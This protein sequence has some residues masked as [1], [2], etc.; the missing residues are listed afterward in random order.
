M[1][2]HLHRPWLPW[3][4][5]LVLLIA[6]TAAYWP[7]F[8]GVFIFDDWRHIVGN[9]RLQSFSTFWPE[10][11]WNTRP[12]IYLTL[13]LNYRIGR[14]DVLGY[15]VL[16][17]AVHC[18]AGLILFSLV[19]GTLRL[20]PIDKRW[21]RWAD[22]AALVVALLW[23]V[24]PLQTQAVT[25]IIQRC[26]SMMGMFYLL[27]LYSV[28]RASQSAGPWKW[29]VA[30]V[31]AGW[32]GMGCKEVMA[33]AP[34][35][36]LLYD[37]I[38][39]SPSWA[40]VFR[41][42][43]GFYL[44]LTLAVAWLVVVVVHN[45]AF[46]LPGYE[47]YAPP[48]PLQYLLSQPAII[49]HYLWLAI[50]PWGELC[51]D[52]R[53]PVAQGWREVVLPGL[54]VLGIFAASVLALVRWPR[55]GFLAF[56]FFLILAPTSSLNPIA[57]L[58]FD[59]RMYL[60][61]A[62][63]I[64]L[65]LLG[66]SSVTRRFL[67]PRRRRILVYAT[68]VTV[69][70]ALYTVST[71]SRNRL[72]TQPDAVWRNVLHHAPNNARAYDNLGVALYLAGDPDRALPLFRRAIELEPNAP[73][74][75]HNAMWALRRKRDLPGAVAILRQGVAAAP[76]SE[77]LHDDLGFLLDYQGKTDEAAAQYR[78]AIQCNPG[79]GQSYYYLGRLLQRRGASEEAIPPL[80]AALEISPLDAPCSFWLALA[81]QRCGRF[82]QAIRQY[83][84]TLE[85]A[86]AMDQA[87]RN[88][89]LC[90]E[91]NREGEMLPDE[92]KMLKA[93]LLPP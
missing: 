68:S 38:Y 73:E 66:F 80:R 26:E 40:M 19:R 36:I 62:L 37:R 31:A 83:R 55:I 70:L 52:Y 32:L 43:W 81:Y 57:D 45:M 91:G 13:W 64:V 75:Y 88:L 74:G 28:L 9:R 50:Y 30:G 27:C 8:R 59:H 51:L 42:R 12:T 15:H 54:A 4:L 92:L 48:S 72:F 34:L 14:L 22:A 33:T 35:V 17:F 82:P 5:R 86:P 25:Y 39:L 29:Y 90:R 20:P 41:R 78:L 85:L 47:A 3:L 58:A 61:L 16:N 46:P 87:R 18:L 71:V 49:L 67:R 11:A 77:M 10:L 93:R 24:H 7:S 60:P 69:L 6:A 21:G 1:G 44:A 56:S 53:W 2:R 79:Y 89:E 63:L 23:L 76:R 84:R 65:G